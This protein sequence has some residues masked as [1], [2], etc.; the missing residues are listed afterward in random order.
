VWLEIKQHKQAS[1][2]LGYD[3]MSSAEWVP[4]FERNLLPLSSGNEQIPPKYWRPSN[5]STQCYILKTMLILTAIKTSNL[6]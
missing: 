2:V 5:E 4:T 6:T 1:T 3:A